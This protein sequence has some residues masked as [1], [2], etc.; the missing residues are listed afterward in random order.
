MPSETLTVHL[1]V[2]ADGEYVATHDES[3]LDEMYQENIDCDASTGRR[4]IKIELTVDLPAPITVAGTLEDLAI[5]TVVEV[6]SDER[7]EPV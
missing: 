2:N 1:L 3:N 4:H 7:A 5:A 6:Q